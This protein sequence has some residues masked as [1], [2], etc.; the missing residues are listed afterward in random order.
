MLIKDLQRLQNALDP[1]AVVHQHRDLLALKA[2]VQNTEVI[3][4]GLPC[5]HEL[6]DD[7]HIGVKGIVTQKTNKRR[8]PTLCMDDD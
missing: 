7:L 5:A 8:R 1:K 4:R 6:Q 2:H 3:I